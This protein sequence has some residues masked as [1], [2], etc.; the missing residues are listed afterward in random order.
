MLF[1]WV[2][3]KSGHHHEGSHKAAIKISP[4]LQSHLEHRVLFQVCSSCWQN[5]VSWGFRTEALSSCRLPPFTAMWPSP[6]AAHSVITYFF[7]PIKKVSFRGRGQDGGVWRSWARLFPWAHQ[8]YNYLQSG[9]RWEWHE[10][11]KRFST[12]QDIKKEPQQGRKE[13]Q[14]WSKVKT[15]T[16]LGG[17]PPNEKIITTAKVLPKEW[18]VW[19][20]VGFFSPG[21]LHQ[22]DEPPKSLALKASRAYVQENKRAVGNRDTTLKGHMQNLTCSETQCRSSTLKGA[23]VWPSFRSWRSFQRG[24]KQL[25]LHQMM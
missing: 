21:V 15:T 16:L 3:Q 19:A 2:G 10:E 14:R 5:L 6:Q 8:D 1:P 23:W 20:P 25:G 24:R 4:G 18:G 13:G 22:E 11:Q 17:W 9:I 7:K 12:I